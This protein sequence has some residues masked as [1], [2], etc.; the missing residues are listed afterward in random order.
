VER[1]GHGGRALILIHGFA[2]SSFVWRNV[3]P[4]LAAAGHMAFA[5]DLL[6]Y[7]ES[8]RPVEADYSIA[9][10]A[11]YLD[12]AMAALR[13]P[14]AMVVG[15]GIGGGIALR[16]AATRPARVERLA[17]INSVAFDECP[18]RDIRAV[19]LGTARFALRV[20]QGVLGAAPLMRRVLEGSVANPEAMPPRLMARYLAPYVG[21][22]GVT[23]LLTL[24]RALRAEDVEELELAS[25]DLPTLIVWGEKDPWLSA[26]LPERLARTIAGSTLV[27]LPDV[28][29]LVPEEA[30][31][32]LGELLLEHMDREMPE[33]QG[34]Q[35]QFSRREGSNEQRN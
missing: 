35:S 13:V 19:Q 34:S 31:T 22:E 33:Q 28:G 30:P 5:V 24:A 11:E 21:A 29:R 8:D 6:G 27:R 32:T 1:Y 2:T 16:L 14:E 4:M 3:A 12:R 9:A 26:E 7:G 18:G 25:L 15:L 10:Q 20:A 17:L 23:H